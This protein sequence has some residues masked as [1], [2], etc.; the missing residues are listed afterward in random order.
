MLRRARI[1]APVEIDEYASDQMSPP[2]SRLWRSW[3]RESGQRPEQ[4]MRSLPHSGQVNG[5]RA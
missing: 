4:M 3:R 1:T 5:V 2:L